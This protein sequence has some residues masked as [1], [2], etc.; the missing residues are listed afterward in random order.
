MIDI[1][2]AAIANQSLSIRLEDRLYNI[3]VWATR[4]V[5]SA[6]IQRDGTYIVRGARIVSGTPL[7]P[8]RY[9]ENGNFVLLTENEEYPD[10]TLFGVSQNLVYVT[11]AE[12]EELRDE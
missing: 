5:M 11:I 1:A 12:L 6:D 2:L 3:A 4:G 10:Y 9:L 7:I 8:Y